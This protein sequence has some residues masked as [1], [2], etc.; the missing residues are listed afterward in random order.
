MTDKKVPVLLLVAI[1]L[2]CALLILVC[3]Y[4]PIQILL[5][6]GLGYGPV[7][8][9]AGTVVGR[10]RYI[11]VGI[12]FALTGIAFCGYGLVRSWRQ[13]RSRFSGRKGKDSA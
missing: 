1:L 12:G 3:A 4:I 11:Y 9:R 13:I 8:D 5:E 10:I 7:Y 2:V 6:H